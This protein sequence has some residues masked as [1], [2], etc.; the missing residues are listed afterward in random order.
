MRLRKPDG[1]VGKKLSSRWAFASILQPPSS[2]AITTA[3]D[4]WKCGALIG[5]DILAVEN[6][7]LEASLIPL[8]I[9]QCVPNG[10]SDL[11]FVPDDANEAVHN[12]TQMLT[13]WGMAVGLTT[14]FLGYSSK[15][16]SAA[17]QANTLYDFVELGEKASSLS[18]VL[19]EGAA[20]VGLALKDDLKEMAKELKE[21]AD[22]AKDIFDK[23]TDFTHTHDSEPGE[24]PWS[25]NPENPGTNKDQSNPSNDNSVPVPQA[26]TKPS[27]L[28]DKVVDL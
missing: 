25:E 27:D 18:E 12:A 10:M 1:I 6:P 13:P 28:D 24:Q 16:F 22:E 8:T 17:S 3:S 19:I 9:A 11:P 2:R 4:I 20:L 26:I 5:I 14:G 23:A 21:A 15:V 7:L